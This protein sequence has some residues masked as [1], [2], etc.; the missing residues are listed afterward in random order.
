MDVAGEGMDTEI[1]TYSRIDEHLI[2]YMG[3]ISCGQD[4]GLLIP[5]TM[6]RN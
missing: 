6:T 3:V 4:E 2:N 5:P 1:R